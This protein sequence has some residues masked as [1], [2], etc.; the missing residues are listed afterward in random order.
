MFERKHEMKY[1]IINTDRFTILRSFKTKRE[2][3][4]FLELGMLS[5]EGSERERYVSMIVQLKD[6]KKSLKY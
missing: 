6:G 5:C 3:L 2:C 4:D 1:C